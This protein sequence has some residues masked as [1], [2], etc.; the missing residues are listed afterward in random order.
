MAAGRMGL[1]DG[2]ASPRH[3]CLMGKSPQSFPLVLMPWGQQ[4]SPEPDIL[5]CRMCDREQE[6]SK[7]NG[8]KVKGLVWSWGEHHVTIKVT[9][10]DGPARLEMNP[11]AMPEDPEQ[12]KGSPRL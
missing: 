6:L 8:T 7:C 11:E 4:S 3:P 1:L 9:W 12:N 10:E 5:R 2:R